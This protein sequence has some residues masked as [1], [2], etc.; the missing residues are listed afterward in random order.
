MK[1]R[2]KSVVERGE[3]C[4]DYVTDEQQRQIINKYRTPSFSRVNHPTIIQVYLFSISIFK[5][6]L[7]QVHIQTHYFNETIPIRDKFYRRKGLT[8]K[9]NYYL[10]VFCF[11]GFNHLNL[12]LKSLTL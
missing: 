2:I 6:S 11:S 7:I 9:V 3:I 8:K 1:K 4:L 10:S 12:K 5:Q